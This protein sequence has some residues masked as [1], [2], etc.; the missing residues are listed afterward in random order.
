MD[1]ELVRKVLDA[2]ALDALNSLKHINKE[3]GAEVH[4]MVVQHFY[5]TQ[6]PVSHDEYLQLV[7]RMQKQSM[8]PTVVF[9]RRDGFL[10]LDDI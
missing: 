3:K 10:Q 7:D 4:R 9:K 8:E 2:R 1:E 6:R 5:T